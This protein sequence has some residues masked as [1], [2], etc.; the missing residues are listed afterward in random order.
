MFFKKEYTAFEWANKAGIEGPDAVVAI[1]STIAFFRLK[2]KMYSIE[3][4]GKIYWGING[5]AEE[6]IIERMREITIK[7][8]L[9]YLRISIKGI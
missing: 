8:L 9:P 6:K 7:I 3:R 5:I 2:N 4:A 1:A